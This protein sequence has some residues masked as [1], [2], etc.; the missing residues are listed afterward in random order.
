MQINSHWFHCQSSLGLDVGTPE[1]PKERDCNVTVKMLTMAL[2][3]VAQSID[4]KYLKPPLG[5]HVFFFLHDFSFF[6]TLFL[7]LFFF[8]IISLSL[9]YV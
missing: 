5:E 3:Q 2:L 6:L 7:S 1:V 4:A 8:D 9:F